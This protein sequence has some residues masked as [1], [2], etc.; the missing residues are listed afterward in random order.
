M[1]PAGPQR[2]VV[3]VRGD[4]RLASDLPGLAA[5]V[6]AWLEPLLAATSVR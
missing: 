3:A 5:A 1:P 2:T 6:S 4:H